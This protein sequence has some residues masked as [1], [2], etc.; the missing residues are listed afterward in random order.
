MRIE[1]QTAT[2]AQRAEYDMTSSDS[3]T[4]LTIEGLI[5]AWID[6]Y[7]TAVI[8]RSQYESAAIEIENLARDAFEVYTALDSGSIADRKKAMWAGRVEPTD[9]ELDA[10]S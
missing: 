1:L 5:V 10:S 4:V 7:G 6:D 9:A 3:A 8:V 2:A